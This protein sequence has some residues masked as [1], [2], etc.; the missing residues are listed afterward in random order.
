L[1]YLNGGRALDILVKRNGF[2]SGR[3]VEAIGRGPGRRRISGTGTFTLQIASP[4]EWVVRVRD[5]A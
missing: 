4:G 5:H 1:E 3:G 2:P